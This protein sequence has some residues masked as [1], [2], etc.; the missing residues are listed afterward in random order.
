M[1]PREPRVGASLMVVV[2][3]P[4]QVVVW[5]GWAGPGTTGHTIPRV[6]A[7]DSVDCG[8]LGELWDHRFGAHVLSG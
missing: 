4:G 2:A 3:G 6:A 1:W 8:W 5:R 7:D